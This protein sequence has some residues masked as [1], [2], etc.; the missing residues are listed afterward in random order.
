ML[1]ASMYSFYFFISSLLDTFVWHSSWVFSNLSDI[2]C[3]QKK[4]LSMDHNKSE[5]NTFTRD[6][7]EGYRPNKCTYVH[8]V[9]WGPEKKCVLCTPLC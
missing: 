2:P 1:I 7:S 8:T 4:K 6:H 9:F 3:K 5:A